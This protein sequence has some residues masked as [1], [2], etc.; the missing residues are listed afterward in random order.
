MNA[1]TNKKQGVEALQRVLGVTAAQTAVFGD[2]LNDLQMLGAGEW[3][4]AM[5]NAYPDLLREARY[6]APANTEYGVLRV[7]D[8]MLRQRESQ[9]RHGDAA[10]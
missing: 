10:N 4:F 1:T 5:A 9:R 7:I 8:A 6:I 2:Y 3:S